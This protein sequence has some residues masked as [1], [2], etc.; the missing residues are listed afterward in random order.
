MVAQSPILVVDDDDDIRAFIRMA[1]E[2]DGY[3]V[4]EAPDGAAALAL[5]ERHLPCVILLDMRM[6]V[7]D[8][9]AFARQYRMLPTSAAPI[10]CMTAAV[11]ARRRCEEIAADALLAKPFQFDDLVATVQRFCPRN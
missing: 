2:D 3:T 8:G 5:V 10:V 9:W 4:M 1:L 7:M 6:P 11:D